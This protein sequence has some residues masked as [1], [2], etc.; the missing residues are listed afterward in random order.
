MSA[1]ISRDGVMPSYLA[2]VV[3]MDRNMTP[4][5]LPHDRA[6]YRSDMPKYIGDG[7]YALRTI[8]EHMAVFRVQSKGKML[9]ISQGAGAEP[10]SLTLESFEAI[11]LGP[12]VGAFKV[13]DNGLLNGERLSTRLAGN[14]A[15]GLHQMADALRKKKTRQVEAA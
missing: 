15:G 13:Y 6:V 2:W 7:Q 9:L 8:G 10:Q 5:F 3:I 1:L 11:C 14:Y 4:D 12:V